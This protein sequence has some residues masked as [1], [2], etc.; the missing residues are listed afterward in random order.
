MYNSPIQIKSGFA[1]FHVFRTSRA[2]QLN[3]VVVALCACFLRL[4]NLLE[5]NNYRIKLFTGILLYGL[6]FC[7][8]EADL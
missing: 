5:F 2:I 3:W 8:Q 6:T 4:L 1:N 7:S